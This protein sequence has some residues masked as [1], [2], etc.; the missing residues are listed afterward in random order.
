VAW[1]GYRSV[2]LPYQPSERLGG[3]SKYSFR[4]QLRLAS[5]ALFSF[6]LVPLQIGLFTGLV[7]FLLA[8]LEAA[9]VLGLWLAGRQTS[10]EPGWSSLM[11][12]LLIVGGTL[13]ILLSFIG[14][15]VGYI[16][17]EVKHRPVYLVQDLILP[18]DPAGQAADRGAAQPTGQDK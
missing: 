14:I 1:T 9:Y 2:I 5:D 6:S 13:M 12:M 8:I 10:L 17:Q 4:R 15:Y 11:F 7:F 3:K 16:F 18:P